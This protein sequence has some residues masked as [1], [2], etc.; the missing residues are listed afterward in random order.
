MHATDRI[1][2]ER[3]PGALGALLGIVVAVMLMLA[4][5]VDDEHGETI[6]SQPAHAAGDNQ[7]TI[8]RL[9]AHW[10]REH[11]G[12]TAGAAASAPRTPVLRDHQLR[13]KGPDRVTLARHFALEHAAE[14]ALPVTLERHFVLEHRSDLDT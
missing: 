10:L 14:M 4:A 13:L 5:L 8:E 12:F 2:I 9:W 3:Q 6:I 7:P 11:P 1:T